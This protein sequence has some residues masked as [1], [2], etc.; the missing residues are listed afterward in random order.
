VATE[1]ES[2][3][4][5]IDTFVAAKKYDM[6]AVSQRLIQK[7]AD[8]KDNSVVAFCAAYSHEL[9]EA[10]HVAAKASLKRRVNLDNI[11][12]KLQHINGPAFHQLYKFHRACPAIAAEAVSGA[13]L[14]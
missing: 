8:S 1:P 6:A 10:A 11:G 14:T 2:L 13:H 9:G 5:M 4:D 12:D 3:G 7:F